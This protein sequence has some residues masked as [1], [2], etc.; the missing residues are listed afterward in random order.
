MLREIEFRNKS[1]PVLKSRDVGT[2]YDG[3]TTKDFNCFLFRGKLF[4]RELNTFGGIEL[5]KK[6]FLFQGDSITDCDRD[7]VRHSHLGTGYPVLTAAALSEQ[8]P[9][10]YLFHN[11]GISGN[12]IVDLYARIRMDMI[13]LKP[14]Y[15]SI[16]V[17]I[18]GV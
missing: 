14:D 6:V 4:E 9:E 11:R 15:M 7:R 17:G 2:G 1:I 18:N 10:K 12:R 3:F 8:E 16:L 5:D 13:N